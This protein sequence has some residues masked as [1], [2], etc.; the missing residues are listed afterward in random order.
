VDVDS[1]REEVHVGVPIQTVVSV[2]KELES[3]AVREKTQ[4]IDR[5]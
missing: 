3:A 2:I 1:D 5:D 4:R